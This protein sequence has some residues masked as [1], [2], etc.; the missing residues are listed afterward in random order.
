MITIKTGCAPNLPWWQIQNMT[1]V[2]ISEYNS[3]FYKEIEMK[4]DSLSDTQNVGTNEKS[5][6]GIS[7]TIKSKFDINKITNVYAK[8][9][10]NEAIEAAIACVN[11]WPQD[12]YKLTELKK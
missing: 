6:G 2:E 10:W 8:E 3:K 12:L 5:G 11:E 7:R 4:D 9:I 1:E